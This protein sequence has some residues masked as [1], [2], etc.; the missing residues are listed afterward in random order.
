[1]KGRMP[2]TQ[3]GQEHAGAVE[4]TRHEKDTVEA[5]WAEEA[6]EAEL[7]KEGVDP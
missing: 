1:M 2:L 7:V 5:E 6:E 3:S 4:V